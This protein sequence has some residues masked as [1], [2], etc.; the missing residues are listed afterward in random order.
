MSAPDYIVSLARRLAALALTVAYVWAL[1]ACDAAATSVPAPIPTIPATVVPATAPTV[2]PSAIPTGTPL[3]PAPTSTPSPTPT[4][5]PKLTKLTEPNCCTQAFWSADSKRVLFIDK[6]N[7]TSPSGYYAIDVDTPA[8]PKLLTERIGFYT[9]DMQYVI[10]Y[11]AVNTTVERVSDGQQ[12]RVRTGGRNVLLSPDRRRVVWSET[13]QTGPIE[14][15][16][17]TIMV[18]NLDG[19]DQHAVGNMLRAGVSAWLDNQRLLMSAR[20]DP[21]SQLVSLMVFSLADGSTKVLTKSE[22]L[23]NVLPSP[24]GTWVAYSIAF[25]SDKNQNGVWLVRTDGSVPPRKLDFFGSFQWRDDQRVIFVPL[26]LDQP[27]HEF[28]E[29]NA[30]TG[31]TRRLTNSAISP[32]HIANGDWVVSPDGHKIVFLDAKDLSLSLWSLSD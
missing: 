17:T 7:A 31:A 29:Y 21:K 12:W 16:V 4:P 5:A 32:F 2:T 3:P 20:Q 8:T 9:S 1:T 22:R 25:D 24:G 26:E 10:S 18:A 27:S 11:D 6:P 28:H 23:R 15:R 14:G 30:A 13:P 19:S